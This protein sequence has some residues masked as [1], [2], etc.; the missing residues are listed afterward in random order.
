MLPP[1]TMDDFK[2]RQIDP[3]WSPFRML[4]EIAEVEEQKLQQLQRSSDSEI[5][6]CVGVA[7]KDNNSKKSDE[8]NPVGVAVAEANNTGKKRRRVRKLKNASNK[9]VYDHG[10]ITV[11]ADSRN[12]EP[13]PVAE[14]SKELIYNERSLC[15]EKKPNNETLRN[16]NPDD[17]NG[18]RPLV[19]KLKRSIV[20]DDDEEDDWVS[21]SSTKAKNESIPTTSNSNPR[22]NRQSQL[23][24][25]P[26][27]KEFMMKKINELGGTEITLLIQ[28]SLFW[29][30]LSQQHNRLSMPI[31]QMKTDETFLREFELQLLEIKENRYE[32]I[33]PLLQ[34]S[35]LKVW[36]SEIILARW[37]MNNISMYILR[38]TW[39][40]MAK[41][42]DL[43]KNDVVQVWSFRVEGQLWIAL[44][45]L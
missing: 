30:D 39:F 37:K 25:P 2:D 15:L 3:N 34:P 35:S 12:S 33:V 6:V 24:P 42:N 20:V 5:H 28:K 32:M 17:N 8:P 45:K 36:E 7:A 22:L 1:L 29:T 13:N 14:I 21:S 4:L 10:G 44:I 26:L 11:E 23:P 9:N 41:A 31:K 43:K 27:A 18:K 38:G 16:P 19:L 40:R